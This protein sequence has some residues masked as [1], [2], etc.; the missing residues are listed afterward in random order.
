M[1]SVSGRHVPAWLSGPMRGL[2]DDERATTT[3]EHALELALVAVSALVSYQALGRVA[4]DSA[5]DGGYGSDG[6]TGSGAA[7]GGP[8]SARA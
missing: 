1:N 8:T 5:T 4:A 6:L 2:W 7:G 3:L